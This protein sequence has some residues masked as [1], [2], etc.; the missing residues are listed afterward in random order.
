MILIKKHKHYAL[1]YST[2]GSPILINV[3]IISPN[4]LYKIIIYNYLRNSKSLIINIVFQ[5]SNSIS[6]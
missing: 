2:K 5:I 3:T 6:F 1:N 4:S